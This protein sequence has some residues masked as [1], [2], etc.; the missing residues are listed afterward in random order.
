MLKQER[1]SGIDRRTGFDR[2]Q[3][4]QLNLAGTYFIE[5]RKSDRD[6]R[7]VPGERREGYT[8]ISKWHSAMV[9]VEVEASAN[10]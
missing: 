6:G 4:R 3:S 10:G 8:L 9:G 2:R 1:R 5:H 7:R